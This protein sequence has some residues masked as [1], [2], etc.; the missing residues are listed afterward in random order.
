MTTIGYG[1]FAPATATGKTLTVILAFVGIGTFANLLN[2]IAKTVRALLDWIFDALDSGVD[3][4]SEALSETENPD[5]P[6]NLKMQRKKEKCHVRRMRN[7]VY[8]IIIVCLARPSASNPARR[9]V[10]THDG[11][12]GAPFVT[13]LHR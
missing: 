6:D 8:F 10:P 4:V 12:S 5:N 2:M 7:K 9:S 1:T 3:Q 11:E 13:L